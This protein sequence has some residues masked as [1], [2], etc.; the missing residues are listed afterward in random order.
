MDERNT[1]RTET[2]VLSVTLLQVAE[3]ADKLLARDLFAVGNE[4][5]L[6]CLS[7]VVD[8]DIRIGS[9]TGDSTN[10]VTA[11]WLIARNTCTF[12]FWHILVQSIQFLGR[13][14]LLEQLARHL[15]LRSEDNA[16]VCQDSQSGSSV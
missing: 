2:T 12:E 9:H 3:S 4:V 13:C 5:A 10:H 14:V 6:G 1:E 15:L 7:G 11:R 16:I 8:E